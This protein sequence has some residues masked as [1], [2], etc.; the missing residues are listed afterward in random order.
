MRRIAHTAAAAAVVLVC[1]APALGAGTRQ[2]ALTIV[3]R[4]PLTI[5][6]T[7]F[8]PVE[9]VTI[10]TSKAS[11]RVRASRL[12]RFQAELSGDRCTSGMIVA[13]G[14][15]GSRAQLRLP[16]TLCPPE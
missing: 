14:A 15:R 1:V 2:P 10:R 8:R 11:V 12:G 9:W 6:G 7:G 5:G 16:L 4:T 3:H 13:V